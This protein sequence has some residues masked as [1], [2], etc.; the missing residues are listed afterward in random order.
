M[1]FPRH[2]SFYMTLH[3]LIGR[4]RAPFCNFNLYTMCLRYVLCSKD[5]M[6]TSLFWT[7]LKHTT[8]KFTDLSALSTF[9]SKLLLT[10]QCSCLL[11]FPCE[12]IELILCRCT[13][14]IYYLKRTLITHRHSHGAKV[15]RN[16]KYMCRSYI[17]PSAFIYVDV[18][19]YEL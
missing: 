15:E 14:Y 19:L 18:I 17:T 10:K 6:F 13:E 7:T 9:G 1:L 16:N 2:M 8:L 4:K 3:L 5:T 12:L 11:V